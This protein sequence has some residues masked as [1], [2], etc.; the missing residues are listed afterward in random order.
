MGMKNDLL[1][2]LFVESAEA[3]AA[4]GS[5]NIAANL[6]RLFE[7]A[8]EAEEGELESKK[9]PL[10][11]ALKEFGIEADLELD[12]EGLSIT[13]DDRQR[14]EDIITVLGSA[15]AM[16]KLAEMGWVV[17]RP[18]D[19]A[20]TNEPPAYRVRFFEITPVETDHKE[21]SDETALEITKKAR[22]FATTPMDRDDEL[23]SVDNEDGKMGERQTGVGKAK[24]GEQPE[25]KPKGSTG[26]IPESKNEPICKHCHK[27]LRY[28]G[29]IEC[30]HCGK[31]QYSEAKEG[32]TEMT[33]TGSMG[34][35]DAG[36]QGIVGAGIIK[37]PAPYGKGTTFAT[38]G[39]WKVKQPV[40][41]KQIRRRVGEAFG[42]AA[43]ETMSAEEFLSE[44]MPG[45]EGAPGR[46]Q[47]TTCRA[48][49]AKFYYSEIPEAR[50][51]HA[52]CPNCGVP[53][54]QE[55][56]PGDVPPKGNWGFSVSH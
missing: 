8:A 24:D 36:P 19:D 42:T 29:Q 14:Y 7:A 34:T 9:T 41:K 5:L 22:K 39:Q 48:C 6:E 21:K 10:A 3:D 45:A 35:V 37:K 50:M 56:N 15:E 33:T 26:K 28:A 1:N 44:P 11:K 49:G 40:V 55:G 38:P 52:N 18:G 12:P 31:I 16:H 13:T 47:E 25:G 46:E 30:Q 51:G 27:P 54:D 17:T 20:M 23:N 43:P 4:E 32:L 53:I 2:F